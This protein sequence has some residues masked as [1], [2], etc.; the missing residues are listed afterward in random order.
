[1]SHYVVTELAQ[2]DIEEIVRVVALDKPGAARS[3]GLRLIEVFG[4]LA[5][6]P[7]MGRAF[8]PARLG[9]RR[10]NE[11]VYAIFYREG[12]NGVEIVRVVHGKQDL[13][14]FFAE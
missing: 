6:S 1:M 14:V 7:K 8:K 2:N 11:G 12:R 3:M 13:S 9:L 4:L 10:F 5:F